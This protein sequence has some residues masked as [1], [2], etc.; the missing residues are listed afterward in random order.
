MKTLLFGPDDVDKSIDMPGVIEAV[1]E[2]FEAHYKG[3][4]VM[5]PKTYIELPQYNGDFRA[6]PAY[7]EKSAGV[8]WVN[9]HPDNPDE[10]GL[11]TVMGVV[12]YNDPRNAYPLAIMD[13]TTLTRYRTGAAAGVASK[14][15]ARPDSQSLG[16]IG[17]GVQAHTQ[18]QAI[19]ALFDLEKVVINDIDEEAMQG[20][21]DDV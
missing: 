11:P 15:L 6:M 1:E 17:A 3:N 5:P 18:L 10:F 4:S 12:I 9:V 19:S 13:G 21:I 7:V 2:A 14:H 20:F 16:L 8:K